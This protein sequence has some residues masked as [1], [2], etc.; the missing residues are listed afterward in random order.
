MEQYLKLISENSYKVLFFYYY[1]GKL[2]VPNKL[3]AAF[4]S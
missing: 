3:T 2:D 4:C 1:F